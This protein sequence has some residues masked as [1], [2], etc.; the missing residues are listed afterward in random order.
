MTHV[1]CPSCRL[2]LA[3][4]AAARL[5][6]CPQC[7]GA[8]EPLSARQALGFHL[9]ADDI[10]DAALPHAVTVAMPVPPAGTTP[11]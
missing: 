1:C 3:R 10:S 4:A 2:R 8:V 5:V 9:I 11:S 6:A 7:G